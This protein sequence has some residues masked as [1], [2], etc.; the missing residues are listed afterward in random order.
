MCYIL[1]RMPT[2]EALAAIRAWY[3]LDQAFVHFNRS[4]RASA[5]VTGVQLALLRIIAEAAPV[6]LADLRGRLAMHPATLGQLV[7]RLVQAGL[8]SRSIHRDDRRL[9]Q[10]DLT[11]TGRR[12]LAQAPVAGP[13]RLRVADATPDQLRQLADAFELAVSLFGLEAWAPANGAEAEAA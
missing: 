2:A 12:L 7:D 11:P 1:P 4:L 3:Q 8:V 10:V 9:R 13:V 6:T 5:G